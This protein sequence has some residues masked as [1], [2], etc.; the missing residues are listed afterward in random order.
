MWLLFLVVLVG[1]ILAKLVEIISKSTSNKSIT[2][3]FDSTFVPMGFAQKDGSYAGF[4]K[5]I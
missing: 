3:G 4:D 5:E 2:I 1:K